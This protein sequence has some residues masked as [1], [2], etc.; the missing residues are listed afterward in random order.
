MN[1]NSVDIWIAGAAGDGTQSTAEILGRVAARCGLHVSIY[2]SY[3]SAIRGGYVYAQVTLSSQKPWVNGGF[4]D[5]LLALNADSVKRHQAWIKPGGTLI[6]NKDRGQPPAG[7]D[8]L[9]I[10]I[11]ETVPNPIMQNV[12][13]LGAAAAICGL[14]LEKLEEVIL[15]IFAKKSKEVRDSNMTAARAGAT[16]ASSRANKLKLSLSNQERLL[17]TGNQA[18]AY[19]GAVGG[20]RFYSAYPMTPATGILH[21]MCDHAERLGICVEQPEDEISVI[22]MAIGASFSGARAMCATSGGGFSLMTEAIGMAAMTETPVVV[23]NSMRAGPST[24]VPTKTE[25]GDLWQALGASQGDYPKAVLAPL[26]V[27]DAF[28][29]TQNALNLADRWQVPVILL[30]DLLLS[31]HYETVDQLGHQQIPIDRGS[32]AMASQNGH[33]FNRFEDSPNGVSAR[34]KPGSDFIFTA[35]TDEHNETGHVISDVVTNP[36]ERKQMMEKRMRKY[37]G[38]LQEMPPNAEIGKPGADLTL[39]GW[40]STYPLLRALVEMGEKKGIHLNALAI[41]SLWPFLTDPVSQYL[42]KSKKTLALELNYTGQLARLIRQETGILIDNLCLK[43]DG[44][45]FYV[46]STWPVI[47]KFLGSRLSGREAIL[48]PYGL[49][50][51]D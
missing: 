27:E 20:V 15:E 22:N 10:S 14:P 50:Q 40:G 44:E 12:V 51:N 28:Y 38:L 41:R 8:A 39:I 26:D 23:V 17:L 9:G 36:I 45:P 31:E 4:W 32:W 18:I 7:V 47:E 35:A 16:H 3:Q 19:G 2:N 11:S 29:L 46:E 5:I 25:Q 21:W 1:T 33:K 30:S 34:A 24:G 37:S 13:F 48:T 49:H 43:Y 6:Y 42:K